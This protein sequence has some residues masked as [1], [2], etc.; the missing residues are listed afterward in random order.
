MQGI[1][2]DRVS[3]GDYT[4]CVIVWLK[5]S[6]TEVVLRPLYRLGLYLYPFY[7]FGL[8]R[9]PWSSRDLLL[10]IPWIYFNTPGTRPRFRP[11]IS[12]W[13]SAAIPAVYFQVGL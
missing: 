8:W 7:L 10:F 6:C 5:F 3:Q 9:L 12:N 13:D 11:C 4:T 1:S 2:M